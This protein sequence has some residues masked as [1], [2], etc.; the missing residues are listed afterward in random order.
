MEAEAMQSAAQSLKAEWPRWLEIELRA[1]LRWCLLCAH[2]CDGAAGSPTRFLIKDWQGGEKPV[3]HTFGKTGSQ[4][5][6]H[7]RSQ[8]NGENRRLLVDLVEQ[9]PGCSQLEV[10]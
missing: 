4:A 9:Q 7:H 2:S 3:V 1:L 6:V 8:G 5:L 10:V